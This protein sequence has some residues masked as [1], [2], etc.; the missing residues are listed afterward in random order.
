MAGGKEIPVSRLGSRESGS[1]PSGLY[2]MGK[3]ENGNPKKP[4]EKCI[5]STDKVD[6]LSQKGGF[7]T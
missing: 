1:R 6:R 3:D 4:V 5:G 2:R 7:L